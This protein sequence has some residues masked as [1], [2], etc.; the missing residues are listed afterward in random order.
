MA[1][2]G[3]DRQMVGVPG[4]HRSQRIDARQT[5]QTWRPQTGATAMTRTALLIL[6]AAAWLLW[7]VLTLDLMQLF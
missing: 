6:L 3:H 4:S 1:L 5:Y 2:A 7:H